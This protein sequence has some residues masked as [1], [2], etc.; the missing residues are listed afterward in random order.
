MS[1]AS[2][3]CFRPTK[4]RT[5]AT[6][7]R[8]LARRLAGLTVPRAESCGGKNPR[9]RYGGTNHLGEV[10]QLVEMPCGQRAPRRITQ[11]VG[12]V[13]DRGA[14]LGASRRQLARVVEQAPRDQA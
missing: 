9:R 5:D 4:T 8:N 10:H 13:L 2:P 12:E 11:F 7:P 14:Q 1:M 3:R 6:A